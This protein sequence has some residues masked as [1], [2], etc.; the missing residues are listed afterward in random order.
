MNALIQTA[1]RDHVPSEWIWGGL[2]RC[3]ALL[4]VSEAKAKEQRC[5]V[6]EV[7]DDCLLMLVCC[8]SASV[9]WCSEPNRLW[10]QVLVSMLL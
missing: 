1:L 9:V 2:L 7:H 8:T 4:R 6:L 10:P 3:A 5:Q